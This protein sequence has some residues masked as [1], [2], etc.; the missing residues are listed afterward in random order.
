MGI[1]TDIVPALKVDGKWV[2]NP[3]VE[4]QRQFDE[5]GRNVYGEPVSGDAL[6]GKALM[7]RGTV[8][9]SLLDAKVEAV[10]QDPAD[11]PRLHDQDARGT[12]QAKLEAWNR[13]KEDSRLARAEHGDEARSGFTR[14]TRHGDDR[15]VDFVLLR[16]KLAAGQ[17]GSAAARRDP[18]R[19]AGDGRRDAG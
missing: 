9:L 15:E 8:D 1:L 14:S 11:L 5:F 19:H 3:T 10:R 4:T 7:K 2:A 18:A 12:A 16:Q 13:N 17:A 6:D